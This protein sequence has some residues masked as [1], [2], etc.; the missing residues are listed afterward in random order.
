MTQPAVENTVWLDEASD[1]RC[2]IY[3]TNENE[4]FD[5]LEKESRLKRF[6]WVGKLHIKLYSA[7]IWL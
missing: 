7:Y 6:S 1:V 3:T 5:L 4:L 2:F